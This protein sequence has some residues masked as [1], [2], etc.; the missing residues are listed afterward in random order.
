[1]EKEFVSNNLE[2]TGEIARRVI[3]EFLDGRNVVLLE[4][5]LGAGKTTF[6]QFVLELLGAEGPFTSPTF[7][8]MKKYK[9]KWKVES[10]K[11]KV[12]NNSKVKTQNTN[13][14]LQIK[15]KT[16]VTNPKQQK[17]N[18]IENRKS[19]IENIYHIDCYRIEEEGEMLDL[20]WEEI[21]ADKQSLVLVEWPERIT[22]ILPEKYVKINLR[23]KSEKRGKWIL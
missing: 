6:S 22:G 21:V 11:L 23:I 15:H 2:E 3:D 10:G 14:K 8:I 5:E 12:D 16:Q 20:G 18:K 17:S 7:V 1:M 19:K 13:Y 4:G 9:L